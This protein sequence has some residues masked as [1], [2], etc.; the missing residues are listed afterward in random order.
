M[1]DDDFVFIKDSESSMYFSR[2]RVT[3]PS[4][5]P[6]SSSERAIVELDKQLREKNEIIDEFISH[7][8]W[9]HK[10]QGSYG[11]FENLYKEAVRIRKEDI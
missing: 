9:R 7:V 1:N 5:K 6:L 11:T 8:E 2:K 4:D 3:S 10:I